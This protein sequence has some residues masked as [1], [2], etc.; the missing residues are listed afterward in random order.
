MVIFLTGLIVAMV[1]D[2]FNTETFKTLPNF[3]KFAA[4]MFIICI[5]GTMVYFAYSNPTCSSAE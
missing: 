3:Y 2:F 5:V 4:I 1:L